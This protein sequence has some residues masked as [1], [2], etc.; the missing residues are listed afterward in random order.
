MVRIDFSEKT[1][2]YV[3]TLNGVVYTSCDTLQDAE[4]E[5]KTAM[6]ELRYG[7]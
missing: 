4:R 2:R 3:V 1:W 5:A 6:H 7:L